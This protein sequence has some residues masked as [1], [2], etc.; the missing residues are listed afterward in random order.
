MDYNKLGK[1]P[2]GAGWQEKV[3]MGWL[4]EAHYPY[5]RESTT[6]KHHTMNKT[7]G[8]NSSSCIVTCSLDISSGGLIDTSRNS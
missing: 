1:Q 4:C 2:E 6:K 8:I 7:L 5:G 3:M